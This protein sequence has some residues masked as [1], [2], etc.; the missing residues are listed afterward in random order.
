M[1]IGLNLFI[2]RKWLKIMKLEKLFWSQCLRRTCG[3]RATASSKMVQVNIPL[4]LLEFNASQYLPNRI[5]SFRLPSSSDACSGWQYRIYTVIWI[6]FVEIKIFEKVYL[7][8]QFIMLFGI[9]VWKPYS[10]HN[11]TNK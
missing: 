2:N 11:K 9:V 4:I 5:R 3:I 8:F 1:P 6:K 7:L 10:A